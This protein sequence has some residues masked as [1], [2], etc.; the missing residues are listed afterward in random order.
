MLA[1]KSQEHVDCLSQLVGGLVRRKPG[2]GARRSKMSTV[3]VT[4][5]K[6]VGHETFTLRY[7]WLK[8]A[9]DA[10]QEDPG[11]FQR[12]D[13]L[14]ILGVGK[15]RV[16]SIRHWGLVTGVLS[17]RRARWSSK[18]STWLLLGL[19][20]IPRSLHVPGLPGITK[21]CRGARGGGHCCC[22]VAGIETRTQL[23]LT[24]QQKLAP[25]PFRFPFNR[26][27]T[28]FPWMASAV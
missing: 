26:S 5:P 25:S 28:S 4:L 14:V 18:E 12:D 17:V 3:A 8:K 20:V 27:R 7:G 16:R 22:V 21:R 11:I 13:A 6:F 10:V 15:N 9:V 23:D 1:R 19:L 2:I 24:S